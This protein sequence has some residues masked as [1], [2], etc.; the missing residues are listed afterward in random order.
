MSAVRGLYCYFCPYETGAAYVSLGDH[1]AAVE[2]FRKGVDDRAD[3][4]VWL[5]VEPWIDPFRSDP[6]YAQLSRV[7]GPAPRAAATARPSRVAAQ[8]QLE[9]GEIAEVVIFDLALARVFNHAIQSVNHQIT[10][11]NHPI[12]RSPN[13]I[14][15]LPTHAITQ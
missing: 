2:W 15:Q 12:T 8:P 4:M 5:G 6:R 11:F 3:C 10:K 13:S 9:A 14:T 1:D 7:V